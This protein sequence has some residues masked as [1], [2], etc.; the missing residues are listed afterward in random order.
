MPQFLEAYYED[1]LPPV[2]RLNEGFIRPE[3]PQHLGLAYHM[4]SLVVEWIEETRGFDSILR[5]LRAYGA[6][7]GTPQVLRAGLGVAPE[8]VDR[9]FDAWL[10]EKYP[11]SLVN[12]LRAEMNAAAEAAQRDDR[13]AAIRSLERAAELMPT[14]A[15]GESPLHLLAQ[16]HAADGNDR[17]AADALARIAAVNE[18]A[19]EENVRLAELL[20]KLGD[21]RGAA[22]AFQRAVYIYPYDISLHTK[23]AELYAG[24][25]DRQGVVR[26]RTAIVALRPVDEAEARYQ[27]ALA[28]SQAGDRAGARRE[29]LRALEVAP[30]FERAQE[31]LLQL[32]A[33]GGS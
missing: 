3:S 21:N 25:G 32:R 14:F 10:R 17:A 23:L 28:L 20:Q 5:M 30:N 11:P 24:L 22:A 13:A 33:E 26:E 27:L 9:R 4:A 2:S 29:V 1:E 15:E 16:L 8:E 31:L 7:Q 18:N 6:G 19:Y 12:E